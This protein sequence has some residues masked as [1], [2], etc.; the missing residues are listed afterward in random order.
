MLC[1]NACCISDVQSK[2]PARETALRLLRRLL[3][4]VRVGDADDDDG[5]KMRGEALRD[6]FN[7]RFGL[8]LA[9]WCNA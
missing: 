9:S 8:K 2:L 6:G 4:E 1:S 5:G 3:K 7:E